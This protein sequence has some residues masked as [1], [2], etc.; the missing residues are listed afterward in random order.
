MKSFFISLGIIAIFISCRKDDYS[1][2]LISTKY[3]ITS[4]PKVYT[5]H[6]QITDKTV[7]ENYIKGWSSNYFFF[8]IDT[9]INY[10]PDTL[11]F[12]TRDTLIFPYLQDIWAKR[13]VKAG[14]G[15]LFYYMTDTLLGHKRMDNV[16]NSIVANIGILKPFYKDA[17]FWNN[18]SCISEWVYDAYVA[19]G[20]THGLE[21]P[22][23]TYKI[24]RSMNGF[25]TGLA[26]QNYNNVFDPS[27]I[28]LL[29][30][31]DTLAIQ[32]SRRIYER[33][34]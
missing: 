16:L 6:G 5:K 11:V 21:F 23:L 14:G 22:L 2:H 12:K 33:R 26:A 1:A 29:Q 8:N 20:T 27:V 3:E 10:R 18:G 31:G 15:Y 25:N 32:T 13:L 30:D 17:C 24:T 28:N 9:S 19:S 34:N 7:I 4:S